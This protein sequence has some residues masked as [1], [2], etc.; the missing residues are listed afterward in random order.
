MPPNPKT[1]KPRSAEW[2][3]GIATGAQQNISLRDVEKLA[4]LLG[5]KV[6][7]RPQANPVITVEAAL[8]SDPDLFDHSREV[9]LAAY[10]RARADGSSAKPAMS[11]RPP[12][13]VGPQRAARS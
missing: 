6:E 9:I 5:T 13:D 12:G 4:S 8:A 7:L 10:R 3:R 1:G 2:W 11:K